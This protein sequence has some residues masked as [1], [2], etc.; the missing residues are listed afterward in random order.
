MEARQKITVNVPADL[1]A[2]AQEATG[3]GVAATVREG[4]RMVAA[5]TAHQTLRELRGNVEF[6]VDLDRLR[7]DR[8]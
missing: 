6:S 1:L 8:G 2:K 4:L 5:R 3:Q 7:E